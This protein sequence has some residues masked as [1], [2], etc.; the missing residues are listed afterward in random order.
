MRARGGGRPGRGNLVLPHHTTAAL[1]PSVPGVNAALA[2]RAAPSSHAVVRP[3]AAR[4]SSGRAAAEHSQTGFPLIDRSGRPRKK[5]VHPFLF[6]PLSPLARQHSAA[7]GPVFKMQSLRGAHLTLLR[8]RG[9]P[10]Q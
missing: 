1:V 4:R 2:G 8:L 6:Q 7:S 3:P 5:I 9:S 10:L